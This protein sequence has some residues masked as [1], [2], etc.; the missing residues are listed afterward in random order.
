MND[1]PGKAPAAGSSHVVTSTGVSLPVGTGAC[2]LSGRRYRS[3][4]SGGTFFYEVLSD[5]SQAFR[6][7]TST[8][9]SG[10]ALEAFHTELITGLGGHTVSVRFAFTAGSS[11]SAS[12][13]IWLDDI[14]LTCNAPLATPPGYQFL[15]GTSMA[16]P[17]VTGAAGLLF[18]RVPSATVSEVRKALLTGVDPV[19]SLTGKTVTGGRLNVST[20]MKSLEDSQKSGEVIVDPLPP[21]TV[22]QT[23]AAIRNAS[24]AA[25][26]APSA[27]CTVPKLAGKTL[28]QA[29]AALIAAHCTLGAVTK[30]KARKGHP[31]GPLIVKSSAPATG[32]HPTGGK[33]DLTLAPK[34]KPKKPHH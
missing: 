4:G 32:G 34:P 16:A 30:P 12:D 6:N 25:T 23:E 13:G 28:G 15:E 9:T 33:V 29:T 3:S 10:S 22:E 18:S 31:V 14:R 20:A 8:T 2:T 5:G 17:H 19:A 26:I 27:A 21:G 1:S 7:S 24:P 11:P